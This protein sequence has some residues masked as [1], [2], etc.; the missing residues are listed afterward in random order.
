MR[1]VIILIT[2]ITLMA[3]STNYGLYYKMSYILALLLILSYGW[4]WLNGKWV[5]V[6]VKRNVVAARAG[7][8][9]RNS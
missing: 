7:S 5:T 3:V 2:I 6:T 1:V 4:T 8:G 9:W